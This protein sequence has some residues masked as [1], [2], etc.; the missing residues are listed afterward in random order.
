M[1]RGRLVKDLDTFKKNFFKRFQDMEEVEIYNK[2]TCLQ[3]EG[4]VDEYFSNLLVL[5]TCVQD[6]TEERL[7]QIAISG[8][9]QSIQREIK[10]LDVKDV[11]QSRQKA[12]F[13]EE[14]KSQRSSVYIPPH[15]RANRKKDENPCSRC[16]A[17]NWH[18]GHKCKKK[19]VLVRKK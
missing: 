10:L 4:I 8:L 12:K 5:A 14:Q 13:I 7:L 11:E 6:I 16:N 19:Y 1:K 9:K 3:Q 15:V 18:P 2:L 17:P